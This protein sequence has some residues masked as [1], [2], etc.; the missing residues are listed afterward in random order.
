MTRRP[1]PRLAGYAAIVALGAYGA[2]T[3]DRIA[4]LA[5]VVPFAIW[6]LVGLLTA[7]PPELEIVTRLEQERLAEGEAVLLRAEVSCRG[8]LSWL[9]LQLELPGA[10]ECATPAARLRIRPRR[11]GPQ[12]FDWKLRPRRWGAYRCGPVLARAQDRFGMFVYTARLGAPQLLR[13]YPAFERL[14]QLVPPART[15]LYAGNRIA[16]RHGEGIEFADIRGFTAGDRVRRINWRATARTGVPYVNDFHLERNADVILFVDSFVDLGVDQDSVLSLAVR[17]A[18]ALADGYLGE[19]DRVGVVGFGGLLRWLL[20]GMG[21]RHFYRVVESLLDTQ[22]V[23]S[24]AWRQIDVIPPRVLP[25]AATIVAISPLLDPRSLGALADLHHR[26]FDL[27]VLEIAPER[28]LPRAGRS[29]PDPLALRLWGLLRVARRRSLQRAGLI[30][31]E[32][33]EGVVLE[34]LLAQVRE[35]RRFARRSVA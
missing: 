34:T 29:S 1:T 7:D 26:G 13:V 25:P 6:L 8:R 27:V 23:T 21:P 32:W 16:R 10:I 12:T 15:Q 17:A 3:L 24:Y 22:V 14:R 31:V 18:V 9:D 2:V 35:Y 4:V 11:N 20:P 28:F 33:P 5:L 19:R 30:V